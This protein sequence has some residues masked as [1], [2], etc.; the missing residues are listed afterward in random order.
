MQLGAAA[1]GA[2][3]KLRHAPRG[4]GHSQ[5]DWGD[6]GRTLRMSHTPFVQR[7]LSR[8]T[9]VLMCLVLVYI[10]VNVDV[11]P[12]SSYG[13]VNS[14]HQHT[15]P[16][17]ITVNVRQQFVQ[18]TWLL[19]KW[20]VD[21]G[22]KWSLFLHCTLLDMHIEELKP[23]WP[24]FVRGS[25]TCDKLWRGKGGQNVHKKRDVIIECPK[26]VH[27]AIYG[28]QPVLIVFH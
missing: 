7:L 8:G 19:E 11:R 27:V 13:H 25:E 26:P 23:L 2:I 12:C 22:P 15:W 28:W 5:C 18:E 9:A 20:H 1:C 21:N 10:N 6:R 14:R 17:L 4:V 16:S 24:T 3:Q